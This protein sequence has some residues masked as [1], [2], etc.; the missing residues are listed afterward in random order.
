MGT[1]TALVTEPFRHQLKRL[2][3]LK[4]APTDLTTHWEALQDVPLEMLT[5]AIDRAQRECEEFPSPAVLR[6][7]VDQ[8]RARTVAITPEPDRGVDLP[9]PVE[10]GTLPTGTVLKAKRE[11]RYYCED[12]SDSGWRSC[13]CGDLKHAAPWMERGHCGRHGEHGAH[14]FVVPCPCASSNPDIL[15]RKERQA[16]AGK[17]GTD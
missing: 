6:G 3:G 11:W 8:V 5:A 16:H 13:W 15:R 14:E 2:K 1:V 7:Y 17:R 9:A 10:L 12:C 4:F